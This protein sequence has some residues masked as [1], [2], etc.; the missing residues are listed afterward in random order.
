MILSS[1]RPPSQRHHRDLFTD[2]VRQGFTRARVDGTVHRVE[3]PPA[4]EKQFTYD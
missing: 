3:D 4:L 2:L 1:T